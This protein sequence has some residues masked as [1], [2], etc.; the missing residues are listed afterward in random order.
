MTASVGTVGR[1]AQAR[2][3]GA[4]LVVGLILLLVLTLLAISGM[5]TAA[6]EL[7]MAGN[8]QYQERAFQAA[9]AGVERAVTSGIYNTT[10]RIG[11]YTATADGPVPTRGTG[12]EG[13]VQGEDEDGNLADSPDCYEYFMRFDEE[14][15]T[16]AV[17]GGGYSLG[18]GFEAYHFIVESYGVSNR[19]AASDHTQSFYVVGPGG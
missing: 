3:R 19:G 11:T 9:D 18:T 4:A 13:C 17:P 15:G 16:T 8:E 10:Q 2:Q 6:L 5:G 1:I 12:Q 7:Q 14:S